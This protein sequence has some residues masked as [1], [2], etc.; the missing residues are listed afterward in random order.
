[1]TD[2][3]ICVKIK[4]INQ[5]EIKAMLKFKYNGI[6]LDGKLYKGWYSK[7]NYR[8]DSNIPDGTITIYAKDYEDFP[9]IEGLNIVNNSD[10]MI[11][12][13]EKDRIRVEP[14]NQYYLSVYKAWKKQEEKKQ[15]TIEKRN[16]KYN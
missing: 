11:D 4:N 12:Y 16:A 5:K 8:K 15:R 1:L 13:F 6:K 10:S 7:G 3:K 2:N 14:T 9:K